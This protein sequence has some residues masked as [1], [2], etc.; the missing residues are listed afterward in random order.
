MTDKKNARTLAGVAM[1]LICMFAVYLSF[2]CNDGFSLEGFLAASLFP[3]IYIP[4]KLW[5]CAP[6]ELDLEGSVSLSKY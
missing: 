2:R 4:L 6:F 3:Y 5:K 1:A